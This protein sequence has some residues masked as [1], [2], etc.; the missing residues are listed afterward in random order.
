MPTTTIKNVDRETW[1]L[2]KAE[3]VKHDAAMA[4]FLRTLIQQHV[5]QELFTKEE[6]F[7]AMD[8]LR[9]KAGSWQGSKEV[10]KWRKKR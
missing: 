6:A 2:F 1:R 9:Q 7:A 5:K 4:D 10:F 8:Q 3:A